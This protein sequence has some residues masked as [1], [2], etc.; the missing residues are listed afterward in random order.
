MALVIAQHDSRL[1][2]IRKCT[3]LVAPKHTLY[4]RED[5]LARS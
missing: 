1:D 3:L 2:L 5:T 4:K